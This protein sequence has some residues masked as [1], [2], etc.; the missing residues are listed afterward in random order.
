[1]GGGGGG[2]SEGRKGEPSVVKSDSYAA[3]VS[4]S[5]ASCSGCGHHAPQLLRRS[6][7]KTYRGCFR[8]VGGEGEGEG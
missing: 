6:F 5:E 3:R 7:I 4:H 8:V 2:A 1:M